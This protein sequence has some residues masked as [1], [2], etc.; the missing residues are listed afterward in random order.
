M[1]IYTMADTIISKVNN[2]YL[3]EYLCKSIYYI[4]DYFIASKPNKKFHSC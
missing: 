4:F 3:N 2:N 1:L